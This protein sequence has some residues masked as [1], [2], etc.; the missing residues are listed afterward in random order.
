[1]AKD[2]ATLKE[3]TV[4]E[5]WLITYADAITL[6]MAFFVM[7]LTFSKIDMSTFE[8][9]Q[10]SMA[11]A[12]G[13]RDVMQ[14]MSLL[15]FTLEDIVGEF[16]FENA[17]SVD[18]DEDGLVMEFASS[19]LYESGSANIKAE[20]KPLLDGIVATLALPSYKEYYFLVEG[21]SDDIPIHTARFPSNWELSTSRATTV[22]RYMIGRGLKAKRF[23]AAGYADVRPKVPNRDFN[24]DPLPENQAE[25]R[26]IAIHL[27]LNPF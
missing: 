7:I 27:S 24:G 3:E 25:N 2:P 22:V 15:S 5:D 6:L 21:H 1:M 8:E 4:E 13:N 18:L 26:R 16:D 12:I 17:V 11:Q 14:P 19:A 10:A 9:V 20:A 23:T